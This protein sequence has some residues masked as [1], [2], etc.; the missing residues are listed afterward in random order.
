MVDR[1]SPFK[2]N[3]K[4]IGAEDRVLCQVSPA[5]ELLNLDWGDDLA[6]FV[7]RY[8]GSNWYN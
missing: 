8:A 2:R 3:G 4:G 5:A 1:V 7:V 6:E